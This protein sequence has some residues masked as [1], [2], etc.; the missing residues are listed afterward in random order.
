MA[1][2]FKHRVKVDNTIKDLKRL[3]GKEWPMML[4]TYISEMAAD[5][6][7]GLTLHTRNKFDLHSEYIP[8]GIRSTPSNPAQI[9]KVANSLA[10]YYDGFGAVYLRGSSDPKRSLSFMA[11]HEGGM[12]RKAQDVWKGAGGKFIAKP[13]SGLRKLQ[14]K[15]T[16]GGVKQ[17]YKPGNIM[18]RFDSAGSYY[19]GVTT[20]TRKFPN[21]RGPNKATL[22]G[23]AFLIRGKYSGW[24]VVV[25]RTTRGSGYDPGK[26][27]TFYT[28][29]YTADIKGGF[30]DAE[31]VVIRIARR[32]H[33]RIATY[34]SARLAARFK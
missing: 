30:W 28:L 6:D 9:K 4:A 15:N 16:R 31:D 22:P 33:R 27:E 8:K 10:K 34:N 17:R 29:H 20:I 2:D 11:D 26:L 19:N 24:P 5:A 12:K 32:T 21:R 25:R 14:F 1:Y 7:D 13:A 23:K 18:Q 3:A